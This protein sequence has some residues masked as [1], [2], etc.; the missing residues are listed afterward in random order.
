MNPKHQIFRYLSRYLFFANLLLFFSTYSR[1]ENATTVIQQEVSAEQI[2]KQMVAI[3]KVWLAPK[4]ASLRYTLTM[5]DA[6][7]KKE[8]PIV[9]H[10]QFEYPTKLHWTMDNPQNP[11]LN[12]DLVASGTTA[13][14]L[15]QE[16]TIKIGE[17]FFY[18]FRQGCTLYT[19]LHDLE[20]LIR[21]G[22]TTAFDISLLSE[23][24]I[25]SRVVYVLQ[26]IPQRQLRESVGIGLVHL[27]FGHASYVIGEK[28]LLFVDKEQYMPLRIV[29]YAGENKPTWSWYFTPEYFI[30]P[31]GKAPKLIEW[32][33][34]FRD[35]KE[36]ILRFTFQMFNEST[37]LLLHAENMQEGKA[38]KI[39]TV[40]EVSTED[41]PDE[42]FQL[43]KVLSGAELI[44]KA[45][46]LESPADNYESA[47][48]AYE[49][50]L[51]YRDEEKATVA[52][53]LFQLGRCYT[54]RGELKQAKGYFYAAMK[55][56]PE[57]KELIAS[58]KH[59]IET[60]N[61]QELAA[62]PLQLRPRDTAPFNPVNDF[63]LLKCYYGAH[64]VSPKGDAIAYT[65]KREFEKG[66]VTELW[67]IENSGKQT[68]RI[69][70]LLGTCQVVCWFPDGK[71]VLVIRDKGVVDAGMRIMFAPQEKYK[72]KLDELKRITDLRQERQW[73]YLH[74]LTRDILG[75]RFLELLK[76]NVK[77]GKETL[78]FNEEIHLIGSY[79]DM[80][81][82]IGLI[83]NI[84]VSPDKKKV[85]F[86]YDSFKYNSD[87][88][89][90]FGYILIN[91]ETM[92]AEPLLEVNTNHNLP[93][94]MPDSR[95]ILYN[96]EIENGKRL[97]DYTTINIYDTLHK[98]FQPLPFFGWHAVSD[99]RG[100]QIAYI[101]DFDWRD[102]GANEIRLNSNL[103]IADLKTK[104]V[105]PIC[106]SSTLNTQLR[107]G[108]GP[109]SWSPDNTH[110]LLK[111]IEYLRSE[112]DRIEKE[113]PY[114][115]S[116]INL[117]NADGTGFRTIFTSDDSEGWITNYLWAED[118]NRI[119][120]RFDN[121]VSSNPWMTVYKMLSFDLSGQLIRE[122]VYESESQSILTE[123]EKEA[124][125]GVVNLLNEV[126]LLCKEARVVFDPTKEQD[127]IKSNLKK[128]QQLFN[129]IFK[130]RKL[131]GLTEKDIAPYGKLIKSALNA[132]ILD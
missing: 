117:I 4:P 42:T 118:Q 124:T 130:D 128:A 68:R 88:K 56:N 69:L 38:V 25:A 60:M 115:L 14:Y 61:V 95:Q 112:E 90:S 24:T 96:R 93:E 57:D 106:T 108:F 5:Q 116:K 1:S 98:T 23:D 109:L 29:H 86:F 65:I 15:N 91:L 126:V 17:G 114:F 55:S 19:I 22:D 39:A 71:N 99:N 70:T 13:I 10:V 62:R 32:H 6:E 8:L 20:Y 21:K 9:Q 78:V 87:A 82:I 132:N 12:Y 105:I 31:N 125:R 74:S 73:F 7:P 94:W 37:W 41:I 66:I 45:Q 101:G 84:R 75:D 59:Q 80:G 97:S 54:Q 49:K 26:L 46:G 120:L 122:L 107:A 16:R 2:V 121:R 103:Y 51:K 119:Y 40:S 85:F 50:I 52:K 127:N 63:P 3:N 113:K 104:I 28:I 72:K 76:V 81:A 111:S 27:W 30:L 43:P 123:Q 36:W 58:A 89:K 79:F 67:V 100:E 102:G 83:D 129:V 64:Q 34:Q 18:P 110:L 131:N 48:K 44:A 77:T 92:T 47:I 33:S 53:A 35:D 11:D